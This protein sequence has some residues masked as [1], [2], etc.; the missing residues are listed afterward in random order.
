MEKAHEK[1]HHLREVTLDPAQRRGYAISK[2]IYLLLCTAMMTVLLFAHCKWL[3]T[4]VSAASMY[5]SIISV[6]FFHSARIFV[7]TFLPALWFNPQIETHTLT[8]VNNTLPYIGCCSNHAINIPSQ[9]NRFGLVH[10]R[11]NYL[12]LRMWAHSRN[13]RIKTTISASIYSTSAHWIAV[14]CVF[15]FVLCSGLDPIR[16]A[17]WINNQIDQSM[18]GYFLVIKFFHSLEWSVLR[19]R[20]YDCVILWCVRTE[21][22]FLG[23]FWWKC[24][25][26]LFRQNKIRSRLSC[27]CEFVISSH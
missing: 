24:V 18:F 20:L 1:S 8:I 12:V 16:I 10:F 5:V 11:L 14:F 3:Q 17:G 23:I 2:F 15:V 19:V 13:F 9:L 27:V 6:S 21:N 7:D 22:V 25:L 26:W 4:H